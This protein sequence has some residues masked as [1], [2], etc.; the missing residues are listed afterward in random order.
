VFSTGMLGVGKQN[1]RQ[2]R[3]ADRDPCRYAGIDAN[4]ISRGTR[5]VTK[6]GPGIV[7]AVDMRNSTNG[8]PGTR[9]YSVCLDDGRIRHYTVSSLREEP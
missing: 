5:V 6:D 3:S 8:G 1:R 2:R 7:L 4:P 9:Q